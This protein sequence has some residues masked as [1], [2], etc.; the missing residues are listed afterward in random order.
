MDSNLE[1]FLEE[2]HT[3][4]ITA[5]MVWL[6]AKHQH[7]ACKYSTNN[8]NTLMSIQMVTASPFLRILNCLHKLHC[9]MLAI[10]KW[11][12]F[13]QTLCGN[14]TNKQASQCS[15]WS[16]RPL[17]YCLAMP[18]PSVN[19]TRSCFMKLCHL[20]VYMLIEFSNKTSLSILYNFT[21]LLNDQGVV[22]LM[23]QAL[24]KIISR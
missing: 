17:S 6:P 3:P 21:Y 1:Y 12:V 7:L 4:M 5:N 8:P 20:N 14:I 24:S 16:H 10:N 23:F 19:V 9:P 11:A 15:A 22:S 2:T 13:E 18:A